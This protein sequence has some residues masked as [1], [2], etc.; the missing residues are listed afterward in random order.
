M[1]RASRSRRALGAQPDGTHVAYS[2]WK[3]GGYR[4]I[5]YVDVGSGTYRDITNDRAVDGAPSFSADGRYIYFQSDRTL[6]ANIY[7]YEI[8][9]GRLRQVTNVI[10]GAY[11]PEASPDGKTLAYVGYTAKGFDLFALRIDEDAWTE[12]LPYV[13]DHPKPPHVDYKEWPVTK[14]SPWHTLA[15]RRYGVAYTG[16]RRFTA[17]RSSSIEHA[18]GSDI[19]GLHTVSATSTV[20]LNQP[21]FEGSIAYTYGGLPFDASFS[22]FRSIAPRGGFSLGPSY[23]P[24]LI[25]ETAGVASTL[26]YTRSTAYDART[27]VI[28]QSYS[29]VGDFDISPCRSDKPSIRTPTRR[30]IPPTRNGEHAAPRLLVHERR[31]LSVERR[32]RARNL[33]LVRL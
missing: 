7:A 11:C 10:N 16:R 1:A 8:A 30:R 25:Q 13:D 24:T 3:Q 12:A 28:S 19:S 26:A 21:Q 4:D 17:K 33:V 32:Q 18:T 15:P 14:Y 27:Y 29:R 22:L 20:E 23:S 6:I 9:S 2:V 5:R 31:T